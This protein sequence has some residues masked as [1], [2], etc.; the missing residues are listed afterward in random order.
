MSF[1]GPR[2]YPAHLL[3][4]DN[5]NPNVAQQNLQQVIDGLG[6]K[7]LPRVFGPLDIDL[8]GAHLVTAPLTTTIKQDWV[9]FTGPGS[10]APGVG[11]GDLLHF[12]NMDGPG[13][14]VN[15]GVTDVGVDM[16]NRGRVVLRC[17][18]APFF[19]AERVTVERAMADTLRFEGCV[20]PIIDKVYLRDS[21]QGVGDGLVLTSIPRGETQRAAV[22]NYRCY[23]YLGYG[24]R[25]QEGVGHLLFGMDLEACRAGG[26]LMTSSL[27]NVILG[28]YTEY[29]GPGGRGPDLHMVERNTHINNRHLQYNLTGYCYYTSDIGVQIDGNATSQY[30]FFDMMVISGQ[31][32]ISAG[33][34]GTHLGPS[35]YVHRELIDEGTN[36]TK[37]FCND[38]S[39]EMYWRRGRGK[40]LS[41]TVGAPD[42]GY[43]DYTSDIGLRFQKVASLSAG[44]VARKNLA[45]SVEL[46]ANTSVIEVTF[47]QPEPDA[48]YAIMLTPFQPAGR[49]PRVSALMSSKSVRP[50]RGSG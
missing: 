47:P 34:F 1:A 15:C 5:P 24:L 21:L 29:N 18:Q 25:V 7:E 40:R 3:D 9:K 30:N 35:M 2:K 26:I 48:N 45:H 14:I 4:L 33:T 38:V 20:A 36:T 16:A 44:S 37:L 17:Y 27:G 31:F 12:S 22:T 23:D 43:V 49:F 13:G 8:S 32:R 42:G 39:P 50:V 10:F 19:T 6:T 28:G 11:S 41:I 46:P